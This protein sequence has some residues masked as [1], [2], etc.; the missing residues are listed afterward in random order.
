[1][2]IYKLLVLP[3][4]LSAFSLKA[5]EESVLSD[6]TYINNIPA[7]LLEEHFR[8]E[9]QLNNARNNEEE[10][11]GIAMA[12]NREDNQKHHENQQIIT[13][14]GFLS[15]LMHA[16]QLR[17][18]SSNL[19]DFLCLAC[20]AKITTPIVNKLPWY[21]KYSSHLFIGFGAF[22]TGSLLTF[23]LTKWLGLAPSLK[24]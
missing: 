11:V 18:N 16:E 19:K 15:E 1:M 3:L 6:N 7:E 10:K 24:A 2:N 22:A 5:M 12:L 8:A 20:K 9:E 21:K 4:L 17:K 13:R 14:L 23:G